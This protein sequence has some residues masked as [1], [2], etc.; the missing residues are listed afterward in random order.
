[1]VFAKRPAVRVAVKAAVFGLLLLNVQSAGYSVFSLMIFVL[2]CVYMYFTPVSNRFIMPVALVVLISLSLL[3][4]SRFT[5]VTPTWAPHHV[6]PEHLFSIIFTALCY[7]FL[8]ILLRATARRE[9]WYELLYAGLMWGTT[10]L[11]VA[12]QAGFHPI[13]ATIIG[14]IFVY[15]LSVEYF[16]MHEITQM[17]LARLAAGLLALQFFELAWAVRFLPFSVGYAAAALTL[18]IVISAAAFEQ[19]LRGT[20]RGRFIRYSLLAVLI[21]AVV[22]AWFSRWIL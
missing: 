4:P 11:F 7:V 1:M 14:A 17:P 6:L 16:K 2:W 10:L 12:G 8:A 5:L 20:L 9:R 15:A 3:M 22:V 18:C 13:R 19:Y 21:T